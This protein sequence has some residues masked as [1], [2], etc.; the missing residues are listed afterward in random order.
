M[1]MEDLIHYA[2]HIDTINYIQS[3]NNLHILLAQEAAGLKR[4]YKN[5][6]AAKLT[7][8]PDM[9]LVTYDAFGVTAIYVHKQCY[10]LYPN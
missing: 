4:G 3:I 1:L 2:N 5:N 9:N 10:P 6:N 7:S 8:V